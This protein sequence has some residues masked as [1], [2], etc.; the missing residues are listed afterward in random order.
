MRTQ[1]IQTAKAKLLVVDAPSG[2][3]KINMPSQRSIN[4]RRGRYNGKETIQ[5]PEGKWS[6]LGTVKEMTEE[7]A[8]M[9]VEEYVNQYLR[10]RGIAET[11]KYKNYSA[12]TSTQFTLAKYSF[13]SL[14]RANGVVMENPLG[15]NRPTL[16][17]D[18]GAGAIKSR[19]FLSDW[20][21][22]QKQVWSN[23]VILVHG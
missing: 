19:I 2:A 3:D 1:I 12:P 21:E 14:L 8:E 23:P 17:L 13:L 16:I 7:Q 9:I 20:N 6:L 22:A 5:L 18:N 15:V 10:E 4:Y 11:T